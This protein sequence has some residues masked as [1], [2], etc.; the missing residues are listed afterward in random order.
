MRVC[1]ITDNR[2]I[3]ENFRRL[4]AQPRYQD[5]VF[6]FFCSK[7]SWCDN[8]NLRRQGELPEASVSL[9]EAGEEFFSRY[10][11]FLSLHCKQMFPAELVNSRRCVNIHPGYN[12]YNRGWYPQVF[13]IL[14]KLPVGVTIHEM[15]EKLDHGPIIVR[16]EVPVHDWDTSYDVYNRIQQMEIRLLEEYLPVLLSG[17]YQT[18]V[19]DSPGNMNQEK[20][21]Q[22][23]CCLDLDQKVT[24][25]EAIDLLRATTFNGYRNAY[26]Y[27]RDHNK[28]YIEV[29]LE[30]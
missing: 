5:T 9:K 29:H 22:E 18:F 28:I 26:F 27:D 16:R 3:H 20:D 10:D 17:D 19:P 8:E 14:N 11:L 25:R 2:M 7:N 6:D 1:V 21:F 12:P 23:L 24:W 15:D 4:I 13:S 30:H